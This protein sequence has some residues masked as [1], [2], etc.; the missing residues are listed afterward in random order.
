MMLFF[1]SALQGPSSSCAQ[2][3]PH[4]P[5]PCLWYTIG[6]EIIAVPGLARKL[7]ARI[8]VCGFPK[9]S[10]STLT[11]ATLAHILWQDAPS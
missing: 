2:G 3:R 11:T 6:W 4:T 10:S 5:P 9:S 1:K 8:K 7:H